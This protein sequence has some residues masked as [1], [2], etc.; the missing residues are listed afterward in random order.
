MIFPTDLAARAVTTIGAIHLAIFYAYAVTMPLTLLA[1][2]LAMR[3]DPRWQ[4]SAGPTLIAAGLVVLSTALVPST[5]DG[6]LTPWLGL[7]ERLYVAI[8]SVWQAGAGV[9]ACASSAGRGGAPID[10]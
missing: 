5:L 2:G 3:R 1:L 10:H 8:P 7:L 9:G 6:P 4:G